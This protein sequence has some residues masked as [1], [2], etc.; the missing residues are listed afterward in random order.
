MKRTLT[1]TGAVHESA[2]QFHRFCFLKPVKSLSSS[3]LMNVFDQPCVLSLK[4][5]ELAIR[6]KERGSV[7]A[8]GKRVETYHT[9]Y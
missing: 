1:R 4:A 3:S 5:T 8:D 6:K 2:D 9:D 7:Y